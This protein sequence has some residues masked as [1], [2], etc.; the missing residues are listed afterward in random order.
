[1]PDMLVE[2]EETEEFKEILTLHNWMI[3]WF[4]FKK[5]ICEQDVIF[6]IFVSGIAWNMLRCAS[7]F[8]RDAGQDDEKEM[9]VD[10][11]PAEH[12]EFCS[13]RMTFVQRTCLCVAYAEKMGLGTNV[14]FTSIASTGYGNSW[15]RWH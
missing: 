11:P 3:R 12:L 13:L 15:C 8:E 2:D 5:T 7:I 1:M 9:D 4:M 14:T 6:M 10:P